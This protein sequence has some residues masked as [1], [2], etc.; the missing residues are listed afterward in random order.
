MELWDPNHSDNSFTDLLR[1]ELVTSMGCT[2]PAAVAL[3]AASARS[4][5]GTKPERMFIRASRDMVKNAMH[6]GIPNTSLKGIKAAAALGIAGAEP[7]LGLNILSAIGR[8]NE[9]Q[10]SEYLNSGMISLELVEGAPPLFIEIRLEAGTKRSAASIIHEHNRVEILDKDEWEENYKNEAPAAFDPDLK[11]PAIYEYAAKAPLNDLEF[12]IEGAKTNLELSKHSI[13]NGYGIQV[14]MTMLEPGQKEVG[15]APVDFLFRQG[16]AMA[17]A[18][19]DARMA[20]CSMPVV[21]NSGSGNQG[22]TI[23]VP[24][25][26]LAEGL[27]RSQED[28]SRA[29]CLAHLTALMITA[30]KE[31][32]SA[33]CGAFTAASGTAAGYV[34]LLGGSYEDV[35]RCIN[36]MVGSL[37][38]IL[39]DGAKGSC[40]LKVYSC[41]E[42]AAMGAKIAMAGYCAPGTEGVVGK[43]LDETLAAIEVISRDGMVPLDKAILSLMIKRT[44]ETVARG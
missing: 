6:V 15:A 13:A 34:R 36:N 43:N 31:R 22:I 20:G 39:C 35:L 11:L 17:A 5:L 24:I 18:A 33:L 25:L 8:E 16:A 41:V 40:A 38:G 30:R 10:A 21:I 19:S 37:I 27:G 9:Q 42:A 14:G 32:L 28:T 3:A 44:N 26:V 12:L 4:E 7:S 23:S 2:E 1:K 29:L